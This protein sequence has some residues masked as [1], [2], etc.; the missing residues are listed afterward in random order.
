MLT[1]QGE[2]VSAFGSHGSAHSQFDSPGGVAISPDGEMV[3]V[4]D[5]GNGRFHIY[6]EASQP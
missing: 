6:K 2:Y 1:H 3:V 4:T 5:C